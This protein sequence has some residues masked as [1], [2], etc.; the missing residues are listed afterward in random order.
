MIMK[1]FLVDP[2]NYDLNKPIAD[3]AEIR[4]FNPQRF[5]ME[6]LTAIVYDDEETHTCV[7]YKDITEEDFWVR[8]HMP[9]FPLLPGVIMCEIAAQLASYHVGR[10]GLMKD[11]MMALAGL[12][13]VRF[14][15]VV[16]PGNRFVI[17]AKMD[18]CRK[19]LISAHFQGILDDNII[20]SGLV[21]GVPLLEG[22]VPIGKPQP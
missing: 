6:Q 17:Q 13:N 1:Q 14:R 18:K 4:K 20:C 22:T 7:G 5:E 2:S 12:E 19:M 9:S 10:H 15:G 21:K 11:C 8:G 3:L 16:T